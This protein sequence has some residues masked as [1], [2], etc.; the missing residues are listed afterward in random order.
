MEKA[1]NSHR[2][3][4]FAEKDDLDGERLL[5]AFG[6]IPPPASLAI[7]R[8][9]DEVGEELRLPGRENLIA[10]L[11]A[12]RKEDISRFQSVFELG[13]VPIILIIPDRDELTLKMAHQML[14][15]FLSL[16]NGDFSDV[17][18]VLQKM[19]RS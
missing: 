17:I 19:C 1:V 5:A 12:A 16:K 18:Q 6:E 9:L 3:L 14:P 11:M 8:R 7:C 15:R 2:L 10:V 13:S 4:F